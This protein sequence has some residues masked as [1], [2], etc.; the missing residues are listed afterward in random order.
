V[1]QNQ[2]IKIINQILL[3]SDD[4]AGIFPPKR[5]FLQNGERKGASQRAFVV[6]YIFPLEN[7]L[8]H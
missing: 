6:K 5:H 2:L 4:C 3:F 1:R 7:D 8:F